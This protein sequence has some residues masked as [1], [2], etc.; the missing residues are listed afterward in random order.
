MILALT[1]VPN[2]SKISLRWSSVAS[3]TMFRMKTPF[4]ISSSVGF[5]LAREFCMALVSP[6]CGSDSSMFATRAVWEKNRLT[7][8]PHV[9]EMLALLPEN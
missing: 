6:A 7:D 5:S 1:T 3:K 2:F 4:A 8:T 9:L